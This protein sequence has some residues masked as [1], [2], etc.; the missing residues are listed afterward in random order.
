MRLNSNDH[1]CS[2]T[3]SEFTM[4]FYLFKLSWSPPFWGGSRSVS[5]RSKMVS[6]MNFS[7]KGKWL[8]S[9]RAR[10]WGLFGDKRNPKCSDWCLTCAQS[11]FDEEMNV[12]FPA[13]RSALCHPALSQV[14]PSLPGQSGTP[15]VPCLRNRAAKRPWSP[16]RGARS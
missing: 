4:W 2:Y 13:T 7:F 9:M 6:A 1:S 10:V 16:P 3:T 11:V 8:C 12:L 14:I 15:E 5:V